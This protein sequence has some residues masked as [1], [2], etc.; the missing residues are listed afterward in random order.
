M[1][2]LSRLLRRDDLDVEQLTAA[3]A[4]VDGVRGVELDLRETGGAG[5]VLEGVVVV[6]Q[7]GGAEVL[8]AALETLSDALGPDPLRLTLYVE[9]QVEGGGRRLTSA[10]AG[11]PL[12]PTSVQLWR[13]RGSGGRG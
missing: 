6:P 11:L 2:L 13:H 3:V 5:R 4:A 7:T 12:N 1:G 8:R 10:D 9:G